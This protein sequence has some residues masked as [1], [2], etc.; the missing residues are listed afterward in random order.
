MDENKKRKH[1]WQK[2][3]WPLFRITLILTAVM[4][5]IVA[6]QSKLVYFP[7]SEIDETPD[8]TGLPFDNVWLNTSDNIK[9][10]GWFISAKNESAV[11]LLCHGN[12]GNISHRLSLVR[13]LINLDLSVF[14]F[15]YR[16]FGKSDGSPDEEGTYLD[17]EAAWK[18][19]TETRGI[20]PGRIVVHGRSLGGPIA[21]HLAVDHTPGALVVDSSFTSLPDIGQEIY[22]FLPV[23]LLSR[24]DYF[25]LQNVTKVRCP[26]LVIHSPS[27]DIVPYHHGEKIFEA[28]PEPKRFLKVHGGHNDNFAV[29]SSTYGGGLKA[30]ID[31]HL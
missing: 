24:F 27:D 29:S 19:L 2:L 17:A 9:L 30:F 26:V 16:G 7:S 1:L 18:Y 15:D 4:A 28:A 6:F 11:V 13:M 20:A 10:H 5:L 21:S 31:E 14:V 22:P 12:A 8:E 25:T 23:H 3:G